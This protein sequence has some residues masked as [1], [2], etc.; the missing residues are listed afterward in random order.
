MLTY[1]AHQEDR[2][3]VQTARGRVPVSWVLLWL[4]WCW[5][6]A[7]SIDSGVKTVKTVK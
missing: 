7:I 3:A 2:L 4:M 1:Q 6:K 5:S